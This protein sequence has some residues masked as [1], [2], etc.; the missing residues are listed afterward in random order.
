MV[1]HKILRISC[2]HQN[3]EGGIRKL[4][5]RTVV[6][7]VGINAHP[8][9][10]KYDAAAL[11]RQAIFLLVANL[12]SEARYLKYDAAASGRQAI[13]LLVAIL[14][15]E[16]GSPKY[17]IL[18]GLARQFT[19]S[20]SSLSFAKMQRLAICPPLSHSIYLAAAFPPYSCETPYLSVS[21][22]KNGH[23]RPFG[24]RN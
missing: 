7:R 24:C 14:L 6:F 23:L 3:S 2:N 17:A 15:S 13:F 8:T 9:W 22:I 12:L 5:S 10:L 1:G 11:G 20:V 4:S 19:I 18:P 21:Q 16:A